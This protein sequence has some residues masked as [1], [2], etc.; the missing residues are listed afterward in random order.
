MSRAGRVP[1]G[2]AESQTDLHTVE[3]VAAA[4]NGQNSCP[5]KSGHYLVWPQL[6]RCDFPY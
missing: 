3:T 6:G 4:A 5:V 2:E 1:Q